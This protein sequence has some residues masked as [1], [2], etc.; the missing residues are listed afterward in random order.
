[1]PESGLIVSN[2]KGMMGKLVIRGA[3]ITVEL[4]LE[5][6]AAD[7]GRSCLCGGSA[8]SVRAVTSGTR[9]VIKLVAWSPASAAGIRTFGLGQDRR[10]SSPVARC[11]SLRE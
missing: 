2:P 3:R 5:K 4:I 10:Q 9:G 8:A 1:M 7:P 11:A 6:F